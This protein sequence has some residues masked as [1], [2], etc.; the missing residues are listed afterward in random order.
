MATPAEIVRAHFDARSNRDVA[1]ASAMFGPDLVLHL[2]RFVP[3]EDRNGLN[4]LVAV[5]DYVLHHTDGT[6]A[7]E[8]VGVLG[9][10]QVAVA[11]LAVTA[12]RDGVAFAHHQAWT[13]RFAGDLVAEAWLHLDRPEAEIAEFYGGVTQRSTEDASTP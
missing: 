9:E 7:S 5:L 6:F 3:F 4:R 1:G 2:P 11:L 13:Y 12:T 8:V 10:G